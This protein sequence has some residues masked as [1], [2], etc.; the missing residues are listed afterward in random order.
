MKKIILWILLFLF[1]WVT[2][3]FANFNSFTTTFYQRSVL[4]TISYNKDSL[5]VCFDTSCKTVWSFLDQ[6]IFYWDNRNNR[7]W[8]WAYFK[9]SWSD[10][11]LQW[12]YWSLQFSTISWFYE[13]YNLDTDLDNFYF[14]SWNYFKYFYNSSSNIDFTTSSSFWTRTKL[15][16][17][18]WDIF[19]NFT[20]I[21]FYTYNSLVLNLSCTYESVE[22]PVYTFLNIDSTS[23]WIIEKE[24]IIEETTFDIDLQKS[25]QYVTWSGYNVQVTIN[26]VDT[27]WTF[28]SW[29]LYF[30]WE[31]NIFTFSSNT[32]DWYPTITINS[33]HLIDNVYI[34][35]RS[36]RTPSLIWDS[37]T[38]YN[39]ETK[40]TIQYEA[41]SNEVY[42][43]KWIKNVCLR[44]NKSFFDSTVIDDIRYGYRV[45]ETFQ[46][47]VCENLDT[48]EILVDWETFTWSL[49]DIWSSSWFLDD[50]TFSV[51]P[52]DETIICS[53]MD[54]PCHLNKLFLKIQALFTPSLDLNSA[55]DNSLSN[56]LSWQLEDKFHLSQFTSFYDIHLSENPQL[57]IDIP[58]LLL[59]SDFWVWYDSKN[60]NLVPIED[61]LWKSHI[62]KNT[63]WK[64]FISFFFAI[65]YIL[66]RL[67]IL[68]LILY[69]FKK[70]YY[71]LEFFVNHLF[72]KSLTPD[73]SWNVWSVVFYVI[74]LWL[75]I[76]WFITI[77]TYIFPILP[78]FSFLINYITVFFSL[79]TVSFLD[80]QFFAWLVNAFFITS[81]WWIISYIIF[82]ITNKF[83]KAN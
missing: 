35:W 12:T 38:I 72:W 53:T 48:W 18:W 37:Y 62:E 24:D 31:N 28:S 30:S 74:F 79:I 32:F 1:L 6:I 3:S 42:N 14:S 15:Y 22:Y 69:L 44:F 66:I 56:T 59:T 17:A 70:Y 41:L 60:V 23:T 65:F 11:D 52:D 83:L 20:N 4:H 5:Q 26:N 9:T 58:F 34:N 45:I 47:E 77:L 80:Y 7:N 57:N 51:I 82:L 55:D 10:S 16:L 21:W 81:V 8:M 67:S 54:I 43:F 40:E 78:M 29:S 33:D 46:K 13:P 49:D 63:L 27:I 2:Q 61:R 64:K 50:V 19:Y 71:T 76:S 73:W 75:T 25:I 39:C 36:W 68:S